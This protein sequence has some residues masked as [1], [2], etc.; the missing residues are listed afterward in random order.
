[1]YTRAMVEEPLTEHIS[2]VVQ[3][4]LVER[5]DEWRSAQRPLPSRARAIRMLLERALDADKVPEHE[6]GVMPKSRT[7]RARLIELSDDIN[8]AVFFT[9]HG[10]AGGDLYTPTPR[11]LTT[12]PRLSRTRSCCSPCNLLAKV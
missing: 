6:P 1:M 9:L 8:H 12:T 7:R 4:S 10:A 2:L 3:F 5:V 11:T